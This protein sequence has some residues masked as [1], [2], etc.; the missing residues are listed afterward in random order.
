MKF[1]VGAGFTLLALS[2]NFLLSVPVFSMR[3]HAVQVVGRYPKREKRRSYPVKHR[4]IVLK[5]HRRPAREE[6]KGRKTPGGGGELSD[7]VGG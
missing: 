2:H 3:L 5:L 1:P 7:G 4:F 6:G